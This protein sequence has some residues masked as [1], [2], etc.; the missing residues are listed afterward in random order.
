MQESQLIRDSAD[1]SKRFRLRLHYLPE[2]K[3]RRKKN[4]SELLASAGQSHY[5][6]LTIT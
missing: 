4:Q 6:S 1:K 5:N 2:I 3:R